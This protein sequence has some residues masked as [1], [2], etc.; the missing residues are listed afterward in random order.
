M[1]EDDEAPKPSPGRLQPL[2]L[3]PM[4][5]AELGAYRAEL[6]AEIA[7]VEAEMARKRSHLSAADTL[8]RRP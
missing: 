7:R 6:G 8:F 5:V 1:I 4:G 3:E 2:R